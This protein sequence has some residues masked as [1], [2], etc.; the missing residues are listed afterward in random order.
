MGGRTDDGAQ[1]V[2]MKPR[3]LLLWLA[4]YAIAMALVEAAIVVHLRHVY[5]LE[6]P[7]ALFPLRLLSADDLALELAREL[8]TVVMILAVAVLAARGFV[9]RFAAFVYVFGLW[10][11]FYYFWLKVYL[12]WPAQWLEWDILFLIP[13]PWFGPWLAPALIALLFAIWGGWVLATPDELRIRPA[14]ALLFVAGALLALVAFLAPAWPLLTGG[15]AA[16]HDWMPGAFAW[17]L[18]AAGLTGMAVALLRIVRAR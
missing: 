11:L 7:R 3:A 2:G 15:A 4:A 13:W 5:Y 12:G 16:F 10:D 1:R 14:N 9:R 17:P 6:N 18:Y 8:A